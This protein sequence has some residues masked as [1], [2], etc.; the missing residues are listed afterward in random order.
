MA[1][2]AVELA[3]L[4]LAKIREKPWLAVF[5]AT[6]G[7]FLVV[8]LNG[9]TG[10]TLS[11]GAAI[12]DTQVSASTVVSSGA[13]PAPTLGDIFV[14]IAGEV[15]HP[16]VYVVP[17]GSRLF[18]AIAL[19]GGFTAKSDQSS[20]NLVRPIVDG[21]QVLVLERVSGAANS[22]SVGVTGVRSPGAS[23]L[24]Q[25]VNLN[26]AS[27]SQL[28]ALPGIGPAI[29]QRI[30]DWRTA[31]GPFRS[32]ADLNKVSGIGEKLI[33]GLRDSVIIP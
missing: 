7:L 20:V 26:Q 2:K 29:A 22:S 12:P 14:H 28:D 8:G 1:E 3:K 5:A 32:I 17:V 33:S 6:F 4:I 19:A 30:I 9:S 23:G 27:L 11:A 10:H 24:T 16:G 18:E 15:R 25:K 13:T 31:N 21:E